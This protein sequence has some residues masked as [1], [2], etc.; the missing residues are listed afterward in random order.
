MEFSQSVISWRSTSSISTATQECQYSNV[1]IVRVKS[2]NSFVGKFE[3]KISVRKKN[4]FRKWS[5]DMIIASNSGKK[6]HLN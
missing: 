4:L 5:F 6:C 3:F 2:E 1:P